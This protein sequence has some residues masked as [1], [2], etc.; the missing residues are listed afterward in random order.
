MIGTSGL[1]FN[2]LKCKLMHIGRKIM[3]TTCTFAS[4]NETLDLAKLE[5]VEC[6]VGVIFQSNL[7]PSGYF[8]LS[9]HVLAHWTCTEFKWYLFQLSSPSWSMLVTVQLCFNASKCNVSV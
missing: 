3:K 4:K 2:I 6:A 7:Q 9:I 1:T 5:H 8:E